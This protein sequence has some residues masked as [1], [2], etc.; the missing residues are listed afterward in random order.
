MAKSF[1]G[2]EDGGPDIFLQE[3][4][5]LGRSVPRAEGCRLPLDW[6]QISGQHCRIFVDKVIR[7]RVEGGTMVWGF[8]HGSCFWGLSGVGDSFRA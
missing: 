6:Q 7:R 4:T 5:K 1:Q 8:V 3:S 2:P